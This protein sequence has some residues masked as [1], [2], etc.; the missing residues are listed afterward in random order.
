M[1]TE[2]TNMVAFTEARKACFE[3]PDKKQNKTNKQTTNNNQG[4]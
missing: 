1:N 2:Q 3:M 4:I